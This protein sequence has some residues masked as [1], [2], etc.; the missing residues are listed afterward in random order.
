MKKQFD[1]LLR[2]RSKAAFLFLAIFILLVSC[3]KS[4]PPASP[5]AAA[6]IASVTGPTGLT[7]GPKNT[8][9]TITGTNFI[10]NIAQ[11]QVKVNGKNCTV[12]TATATSITAQIPPA[13]GTGIVE[14]FLNGTRYVGPVFNFIFTYTLISLNDGQVGNVYGPIATAKFDQIESI[15]IDQNNSLFLGQ[16]NF[17]KVKKVTAAGIVSLLAG[18]GIAGYLD[19]NGATAQ[20]QAPEY[21]SAAADGNIYVGDN[22]KVRKIDAAG[23]VTTLYTSLSSAQVFGIKAMPS[24]IYLGG[25][26][27]IEKISYSGV[28]IWSLKTKPPQPPFINNYDFDGDTSVVRFN[29]YGNIEVDATE[30]NIYFSNY[31]PQNVMNGHPV[32]KLKKLNITAHT[33]T[34]VAGASTGV[35]GL[36][37]P[38]LQATF[39]QLSDMRF[40]NSDGLWLADARNHKVRMLKTGTVSTIIGSAGQGDVDGDLTIAKINFPTGF[41]F[42]SLGQLYIACLGNNKI[43]KLV[44]D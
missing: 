4:D 32:W 17:P 25:T 8:I 36:D 35:D 19:A 5:P 12:L 14:L 20:F 37:G 22:N 42:D 40:D 29:T 33:I 31:D 34:T 30:Q 6:T 24:G 21:C 41:A 1:T 2:F 39:N 18:S 23:N 9:I 27:V 44:I 43:K 7:S 3:N 16:Y 11:I 13:C 28:L 15:S 26:N 10:T 38:A